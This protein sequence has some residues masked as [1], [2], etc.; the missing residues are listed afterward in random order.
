MVIPPYFPQLR[1]TLP[2][3]ATKLPC[4]HGGLANRRHVGAPGG[5]RIDRD[6]NVR[7]HY[8]NG[9]VAA[10]SCRNWPDNHR[11][12]TRRILDCSVIEPKISQNAGP[13]RAGSVSL[14]TPNACTQCHADRLAKWA[15]EA[16][17]GWYPEGRQTT[18]HYGTAVHSG[19]IGA[20]DAEQQLDR[21]I[22]DRS[23]P[24]VARASALRL[25]ASPVSEPALRAAITDPDPR[26]RTA[27]PRALS[28]SAP[29]ATRQALASLL[30]DP[31]CAVRIEAARPLAGTDLLSLTPEQ[32]TAFV[33]ATKELVD[34]DR[35]EAHLNLGLLE[36][37]R[38][39]PAEA[40][41]RATT[42]CS[43]SIGVRFFSTG[44]R[45]LIS[46]S[47]SSPLMP[48]PYNR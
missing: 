16:V 14:G 47:A 31:V 10:P 6:D 23:Q 43:I 7:L 34:A 5:C 24:A 18:P 48:T 44:L 35:P 29:Q 32:Q 12:T 4:L 2:K 46:C 9:P 15:A 38:Q 19:R 20:S 37:R 8:S 39:Q 25:Y 33:G 36:T 45:R 11:D 21:L 30:R 26:V 28:A 17:A 13:T 41:T 40:E 22:L 1:L 27:V 3:A 42:A